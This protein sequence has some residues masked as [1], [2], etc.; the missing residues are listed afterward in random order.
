MRHRISIRKPYWKWNMTTASIN[1]STVAC[2]IIGAVSDHEHILTCAEYDS[3]DI[4][5]Y[6]L[7]NAHAILLIDTKRRRE[8]F[9]ETLAFNRKEG[10]ITRGRERSRYKLRRELERPFSI[11]EKI[12]YCEHIW[13]VHNRNCD[14]HIGQNGMWHSTP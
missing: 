3:S 7:E 4:Y 9:D 12:H 2:G 5:Y 11:L 8:I 13:C 6:V 14:V 10:I 1:D